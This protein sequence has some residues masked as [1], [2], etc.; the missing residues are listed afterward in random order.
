MNILVCVPGQGLLCSIET[1]VG[2]QGYWI[3][4]CLISLSTGG[5]VSIMTAAVLVVTRNT[6]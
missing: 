2:V 4:L 6:E 5:I 3:A 1:G